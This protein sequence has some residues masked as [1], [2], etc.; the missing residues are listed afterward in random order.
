M[1]LR[2]AALVAYGIPTIGLF[3]QGVLYVTTSEFMPYHSDA[4][5][6]QW[7]ELPPNYQGFI[8]G[9]IKAM[10]AGSIGVSVSIAFML[11]IP[12]RRGEPWARW[13]V[14]LV[15]AVFTL[16]TAYAAFTIDQTTPASPP[17][18]ATLG[19]TALYLA[20]ALLSGARRPTVPVG[21]RDS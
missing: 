8:L 9:A 16:L 17:W 12:F 4:L 11:A 13:S 15:G 1:T 5:G 14:T 6:V 19:L 10:G 21:S 18:R 20:G 7:D 3:L 2:T